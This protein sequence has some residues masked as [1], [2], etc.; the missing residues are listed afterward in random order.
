M[1]ISFFGFTI[2][3]VDELAALRA[4]AAAAD[5]ATSPDKALPAD[6]AGSAAAAHR[7]SV[8]DVRP[9]SDGGPPPAV[10]E[11]LRLADGLLDLTGQ[12]ASADQEASPVLRWVEA[13][14]R[15]LLAACDITRIE[16][17]GSFDP[18]RHQA[19]ASRDAP[20]PDLSQQIADTVRPGYAWRG[21]LL[22]P[23]QVVV[24]S[25]KEEQ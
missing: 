17:T 4:K 9:D 24:Y 2:I 8:Q 10:R 5:E 19:V 1:S 20:S 7:T 14:I 22:C 15:S 3:R 6:N 23:Q 11:V 25:L 18:S 12:G 21:D 16:E 13:R